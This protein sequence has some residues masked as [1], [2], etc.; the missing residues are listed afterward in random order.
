[1]RAAILLGLMEGLLVALLG[2][3]VVLVYKAERFVNFANAQL[4]VVSSLLLAKLG[5]DAG[6][7]WYLALVVAVGLGVVVGAGCRRLV[8]SKFEEASRTSLMIGTLGL[9]QILLALTHFSWLNPDPDRLRVEGYPLPFEIFW[10]FDGLAITAREVLI[11]VIVPAVLL[12]LGGWLRTSRFG[13][14]VRAAA[15]NPDAARLAGVDVRHT[16]TVVWGIA[17][18][19]SAIGAV[20]AAPG[21]AVL[22]VQSSGPVLLLLSLGAAGLAGFTS[23]PGVVV[24][25]VG[26]GVAEGI[27][28]HIGHNTTAGLAAVVV[29][30]VVGLFV[31][32]MVVGSDEAAGV[33]IERSEEPVRIPQSLRGSWVIRRH[34]WVVIAA[35]TC[36]GIVLPFLPG[37]REPHWTY[38]LA[39][40]AVV[41]VAGLSLTMLS[42]WA[43]QISLG[44]FAFVAVGAFAAARLSPRGW[45]L[46]ATMV[47]AAAVGAAVAAVVGLPALRSRGLTFAVT[48]LGLAVIGPVW[49]FRQPWVLPG[50]ATALEPA[51]QAGFGRLATQKSVYFVALV[52]LVTAGLVLGRL[53]S[54]NVGRAIV[55]V[56]DNPRAA[57]TFALSPELTR[58]AAFAMS[59]ALA[60]VAGVLWVA[61]N[62]GISA[63]LARPALSQLMLS[64]VVIGGQSS[65]A[66]AVLGSVLV[67]GLPIFLGDP[68]RALVSDSE[69]LQLFLAGAGLVLVQ[70]A[71]PTG[72]AGSMRRR[73]QQHIDHRA[74]RSEPVEQ[75]ALEP[76]RDAKRAQLGE[77]RTALPA[78]AAALAVRDIRVAFEGVHAVDG[79]ALT[80]SPGEIV[81]VIGANGAGKTTLLD[82]ICG[83]VSAGGSIGICG[84]EA[85]SLPAD[86]RAHLGLSRGFQ[87]AR[88]FP[89]LTVREIVELA[90][91]RHH[92]SGVLGPFV[93]TPWARFADQARAAEADEII[94]RFGLMEYA[95]VP[96]D[97]LSTGTRHLCD[98]AAQVATRPRLMVLDEPTSGIAQRETEAFRPMIRDLA[99]E[100]G[101]A[102][103]VVEHDMPFLMSVAD[104]IYC[105]DRGRVIAEGSPKAIRKD[106]AVIASYLGVPTSRVSKPRPRRRKTPAK[107]L[108]HTS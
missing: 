11:A 43:G 28:A 27:G 41:A 108:G 65:V 53:R 67:F 101:C 102:M 98:L 60:A 71:H 33:R 36:I 94:G 16:S 58:L 81:G 57:A 104:R 63:E 15:S 93:A 52:V 17:G 92:P 44:Q 7:S 64:A 89:A 68:L 99:G 19:L 30:V 56:R 9:S 38:V 61:V 14:V 18:G 73:F 37:L 31:R 76:M 103:L 78:D 8:I 13:R 50:T 91:G 83:L 85:A 26:L 55:A 95:D 80:V 106:P 35:S 69:Q 107:M 10:E 72:L 3:G 2:V 6:M 51:Y 79:V 100:L 54:S 62:R 49:L 87:D 77:K 86:R 70:I 47:V 40:V 96:S 88:L 42:G 84:S 34:R 59:G 1:M 29:T 75:A 4:G 25:G 45:S 66:G 5:I 97:R 32:S 48:T 24:A 22:E 23:I 20:L 46:L 90:L 74:G 21:Q 39:H 82:A 105:L 12:L